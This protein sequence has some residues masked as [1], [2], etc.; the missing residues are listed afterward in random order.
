MLFVAFVRFCW[1][2]RKSL[3][4][5]EGN[6]ANKDAF[7]CLCSLLLD[8]QK[9]LSFTEDNQANKDALRCLCSLLLD[10]EKS[11]SFTEGN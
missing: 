3:S 5:T 2:A 7:R 9:S 10:G 6:Q 11:L 1:T 4:F 8:G